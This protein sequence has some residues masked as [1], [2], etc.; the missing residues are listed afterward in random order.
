[1][2]PLTLEAF[3]LM[4]IITG[5]QRFSYAFAL[6][7][8]TILNMI[9]LGGIVGLMTPIF[10]PLQYVGIIFMR[11]YYVATVALLFF[12][13]FRYVPFDMMQYV[14]SIKTNYIKLIIYTALAIILFGYN[15]FIAR[16]FN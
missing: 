8:N 3:K 7:F 10:S 12:I 11:P 1:M 5:A 15:W 14:D 9:V 2:R 13:N 16:Y 6:V 4:Y